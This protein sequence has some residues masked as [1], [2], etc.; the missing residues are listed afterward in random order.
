MTLLLS[1]LFVMLLACAAF[2]FAWWRAHMHLEAARSSDQARAES[3]RLV[4][5]LTEAVDA[6]AGL[7]D[8]ADQVA[9]LLLNHFEAKGVVRLSA[10]WR[11]D[12]ELWVQA[13]GGRHLMQVHPAQAELLAG[14]M[15]QIGVAE[16]HQAP[17]WPQSMQKL[18]AIAIPN[19]TSTRAVIEL[20]DPQRWPDDAQQVLR[21]S[22]LL[23]QSAA[24][25]A[26]QTKA[27]NEK[28]LAEREMDVEQALMLGDIP[29]ATILTDACGVI[30]WANKGLGE[31]AG[32]ASVSF[33]GQ[34]LARLLGS[35]ASIEALEQ[36]FAR[37]QSFRFEGAAAARAG[38]SQTT[39]ME[40][41]A[42]WRQAE[43]GSGRSGYLCFVRDISQRRS[44]RQDLVASENRFRDVVEGIEDGIFISTPQRD[45]LLPMGTRWL[46]IFGL[47]SE[48]VHLDPDVYLERVLPQDR[49]LL[50]VH[51]EF[52]AMLEPTDTVFRIQHPLLG[53]RWL[54]QRTRTRILEDG[55]PRV[56]GVVTDVTVDRQRE[57]DLQLARD[58]AEAASQAKS[59]FLANMSHEIRTPMNG[60]LGMTEL[61]LGTPLNDKQRRFA[62]A[63]L[64]SGESLLEIINDILDFAK[65]EAGRLELAPT[66]LVVRSLVEDT[67]ELLAPRA[68]EKG[69]EVTFREA[70]ELP[71]VIWADGL[72]LRQVLTNLVA[73][74]IKFTERGEV[75]VD[76]SARHD[77]EDPMKID[78]DVRVRDTGIG[79]AT[80]VLPKLFQAFSQAHG[81]MSR[82]YGGTGLGLAI[83]KQLVELMGG[84]VRVTSA[85]GQGSEFAFTVPANVVIRDSAQMSLDDE[86]MPALHV[87]VVD[88]NVTNRTVLENML[89][90]WGMRVT[91]ACDGLDALAKIDADPELKPDLA[92]VDMHMPH[93]DGIGFAKLVRARPELDAL[94]LILL[95]SVSSPDDAK[96]AQDAGFERFIA[97]PVRK[98]ELRQTLLGMS[99]TRGEVPALPQLR[100]SILVVEDNLVNQEVV[101]QMLKRLGCRVTVANSGMEGLQ[102]LCAKAF[103]AVLMDIQMP[104]M[105]G[106]EALGW[107]R[108]GGG[109][110]FDF[111]T[112]PQ[113]PVIAVTANALEGD[114]Q[115]FLDLGFDDYLAKPFRQG[116]LVSLLLRNL[117][118]QDVAQGA[119]EAV[120]MAAK[121][122]DAV[123]Q[124]PSEEVAVLDAEALDRLRDLDPSGANKVLAR[125]F[126]AYQGSVE[127]LIPQLDDALRCADAAGMRHVVHTLKSSSASVGALKLGRLCADMEIMVREGV[128]EG[129]GPR[130]A[131]IELE[132]ER[133]LAALKAVHC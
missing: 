113:T 87:L 108:R 101:G 91:L 27:G 53:M 49:A 89:S 77:P 109:G 39:W 64:R 41:D 52:E 73:N 83:S 96:L 23:L 44:T 125:V 107:F 100:R 130:V 5:D 128:L 82:R 120:P 19:G 14:T 6:A 132:T 99:G 46:D 65:I 28:S 80:E 15:S 127:R 10:G 104:G 90:A 133:V 30:E 131:E 61:L 29:V 71:D 1:L 98:A 121:L 54:R 115:R 56:Y 126:K 57:I 124:D 75:T 11:E 37:A 55:L 81:G 63:V 12:G 94:K 2:G 9:R 111:R 86:P 18:L 69:I 123:P 68:H 74:A 48:E 51:R 112:L 67:L 70:P 17:W 42:I 35:T 119:I 59:Q 62:Q 32:D 40:F 103:D 88:D 47:S 85:L 105:D 58:A 66:D 7:D 4:Q 92:V 21:L 60:I 24:R 106:V 26:P 34:S 50:E 79:I 33:V 25:Q 22:R 16:L 129:L 95:S 114:Q 31:L 97:K 43:V 122:A 72:R 117:N 38:Q 84:S 78:L 102:A 110:R 13:P 45:Q 20:H 93:L 116:Q 118:P 36:R 8:A 76:V 3:I